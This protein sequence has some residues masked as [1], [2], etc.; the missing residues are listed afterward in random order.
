M[1]RPMS[2]HIRT[3]KWSKKLHDPTKLDRRLKTL[4]FFTQQE[5]NRALLNILEN[6]QSK[7]FS[8]EYGFYEVQCLYAMRN[9]ASHGSFRSF[10]N[11]R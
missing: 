8:K 7:G 11:T 1:H 5:L 2:C 4:D 10:S 9:I 6:D 3:R